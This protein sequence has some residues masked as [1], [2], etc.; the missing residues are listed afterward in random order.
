MLV[1]QLFAAS[2]GLGEVMQLSQD[3]PK[4]KEA[5]AAAHQIQ[6]GT[7]SGKKLQVP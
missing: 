2:N 7:G 6:I 3:A 1:T 4:T 5:F